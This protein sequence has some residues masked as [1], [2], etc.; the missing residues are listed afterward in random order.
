MDGIKVA[1]HLTL[2]NRKV[3]LDSLGGPNVI[4]RTLK[5]DRSGRTREMVA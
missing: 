5:G 2:K 3:V 1:N 4:T